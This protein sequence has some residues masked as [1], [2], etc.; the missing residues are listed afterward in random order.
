MSSFQEALK[1]LK[2]TFIDDLTPKLDAIERLVL[3]IEHDFDDEITYDELYRQIHNLK[4]SAGVYGLYVVTWICHLIEDDMGQIP[5]KTRKNPEKAIETII[6][7]IDILRDITSLLTKNNDAFDDAKR[8]T[9]IIQRVFSDFK[10]SILL[11]E[12]SRL[13]IELIKRLASNIN[14]HLEIFSDGNEALE[15]A[16]TKDFDAAISS[17]EVNGPN[18]FMLTKT[19]KENYNRAYHTKTILLT[20]HIN[21]DSQYQSADFIVMKDEHFVR[22]LIAAIETC[23][24]INIQ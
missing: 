22:N 4:G 12:Q 17:I 10:A 9:D 8:L 16:K 23:I 11:I 18:S 6:V 20:S 15:K 21:I 13:I 7:Y 1:Q 24:G 14:C 2:I 19:L 3:D 5:K